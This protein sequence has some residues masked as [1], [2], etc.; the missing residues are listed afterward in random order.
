MSAESCL[1]MGFGDNALNRAASEL[2]QDR[3]AAADRLRDRA[4]EEAAFKAEVT[5]LATAFRRRLSAL[6]DPGLRWLSTSQRGF[7]LLNFNTALTVD[8]SWVE[9]P[10]SSARGTPWGVVQPRRPDG[11]IWL[12]I[13]A[14]RAVEHLEALAQH[15]DL[16]EKVWQKRRHHELDVCVAAFVHN[17]PRLKSERRHGSEYVLRRFGRVRFVA[18]IDD[19]GLITI[20]DS[21]GQVVERQVLAPSGVEIGDLRRLVPRR[22][23]LP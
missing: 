5:A 9:A 1:E 17:R 12:D 16:I 11:R 6:G 15:R 13:V 3:A 10:T 14:R 22:A 4:A 7:K 8:G 23:P 18:T 2:A 19:E 21:Q 20:V